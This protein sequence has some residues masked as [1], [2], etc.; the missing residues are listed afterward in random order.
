[1]AKPLGRDESKPRRRHDSGKKAAI[2]SSEIP[3]QPKYRHYG[4]QPLKRR[5][6]LPILANEIPVKVLP[7]EMLVDLTDNHIRYLVAFWR[8]GKEKMALA[9]IGFSQSA[10][11]KWKAIESF[12]ACFD[13][14]KGIIDDQW[15]DELERSWHEGYEEHEDVYDKVMDANGDAVLDEEGEQVYK[16]RRAKTRVKRDPGLLK[17]VLRSRM[18][19]DFGRPGQ[20]GGGVQINVIFES[21][22]VKQKAIETQQLMPVEIVEEGEDD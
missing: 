3:G 16:R 2:R 7:R 14:M 9:E 10:F 13:L 19:E 4:Q 1:M 21:V 8:L 18:P 11:S 12:R 15:V 17:E 20:G 6:G 5:N 22:D